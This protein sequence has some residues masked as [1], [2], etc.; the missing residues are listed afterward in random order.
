MSNEI[1]TVL[2]LT[3]F[4]ESHG[5]AMGG[6]IDGFPARVAVDLERLQEQVSR[7]RPGQSAVTTQRSEQDRVEILSGI[8][9]GMTLGTPIGF[10]VRNTDHR[11]EEAREKGILLTVERMKSFGRGSPIILTGDLNCLENE[12][13]ALAVSKLLKDALYAS[14]TTPEG[15]WRTFNGWLWD[16]KE[17]TIA[18]A[19]KLDVASRSATGGKRIDYIYVSPGIRVQSF[20]TNPEPR[21]GRKSFP[22]DHFPTVAEIRL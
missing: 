8:K 15:T 6:V 21:P 10:I 2:R 11:S 7:R 12:K 4:G 9:D 19:F 3:T 22:S 18:D 14:E 16:D 1:G 13:P 5:E 17:L 20:R